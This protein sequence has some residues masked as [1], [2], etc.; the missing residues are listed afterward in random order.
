MSSAW[1]GLRNTKEIT[2]LP[3]YAVNKKLPED[4]FFTDKMIAGECFE[5]FTKSV[6]EDLHR[7]TFIDPSAGDGCFYDLLP[8]G[9]RVAIDILPRKDYVNKADFLKWYPADLSKKYI[10]IGNPPF[11]IRGAYALAFI[12]RALLFSEYVGFILPM[13]FY[14]NGKGT[15]MLRVLNGQLL[16]T[17][18]L[19]G[20]CFYIPDV[21]KRVS[22]NTVFQV[23]KRGYNKHNFEDYDVSEYAEIFTVCSSPARLCG[24]DKLGTYDCYISSSFYND[25]ITIVTDFEEVKYGSGYGLILKKD[26]QKILKTLGNTNWLKFSSRATNHCRHIRMHSV[27]QALGRAGF[28]VLDRDARLQRQF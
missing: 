8:E 15:N 19:K 4:S 20:D 24:L 23:W 16:H 14:T 27:R 11:G 1:K 21:N 22:I 13:S 28:G 9:R 12:N 18:E 7:F 3:F 5:L 2:E 17:T 6:P 10:T 25:D 26:K